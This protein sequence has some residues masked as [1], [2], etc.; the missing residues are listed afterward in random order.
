MAVYRG[1]RAMGCWVCL[2]VL[3]ASKVWCAGRSAPGIDSWEWCK[4]AAVAPLRLGGP[5]GARSYVDRAPCTGNVIDACKCDKIAIEAGREHT[6]RHT[7]S[8]V[9][10]NRVSEP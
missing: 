9:D 8:S 7:H 5:E 1:G 10:V 6:F 3:E 2:I 4:L